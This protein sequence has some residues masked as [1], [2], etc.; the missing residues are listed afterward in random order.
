MCNRPLTPKGENKG[1]PTSNTYFFFNSN[2]QFN[3]I[4]LKKKSIQFNSNPKI[5]SSIQF[6][7]IRPALTA[8]STIYVTDKKEYKSQPPDSDSGIIPIKSMSTCV[9]PRV[10][11]DCVVRS[12]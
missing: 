12:P 2:F 10:A 1:K 4:K 9:N 11:V 7:S 6:N 3:S 5:T 8:L